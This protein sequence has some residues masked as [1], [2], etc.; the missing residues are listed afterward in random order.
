VPPLLLLA[1]EVNGMLQFCE[2]CV[3]PVDVLFLSP[4]SL[5]AC[6]PS[7]DLGRRRC[8]WGDW[9]Q[10]PPLAWTDLLPPPFWPVPTV[11]DMFACN[12]CASA[13]FSKVERLVATKVVQAG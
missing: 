8:S 10:S 11:V 6:P 5:V 13:M 3:L 1:K 12:S 7:Q 2:L 9:Y 4:S